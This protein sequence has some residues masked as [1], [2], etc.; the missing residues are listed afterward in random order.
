MTRPP[1]N[2]QPVQGSH[3][4]FRPW[5]DV[6]HLRSQI[7]SAKRFEV[8]KQY[9]V[10][11]YLDV[12]GLRGLPRQEGKL[13]P[14]AERLPVFSRYLEGG[15][16]WSAKAHGL[17]RFTGSGERWL[18]AEVTPSRQAPHST[19]RSGRAMQGSQPTCC[20]LLAAESGGAAGRLPLA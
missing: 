8:A 16:R 18:V 14:P 7:P 9:K 5:E 6:T 17:A 12:R 3:C 2:Q 11:R 13:L 10:S 4:S 20:A 15:E 1:Q 19:R